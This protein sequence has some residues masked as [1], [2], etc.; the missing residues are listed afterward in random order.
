MV[1]FTVL[2]LW[3]L[4]SRLGFTAVGIRCLLLGFSI[5]PCLYSSASDSLG[6]PFGRFL[7]CPYLEGGLVI[8]LP[9][10]AGFYAPAWV[11]GERRGPIC[12]I[13]I[14]AKEKETPC[15][16]LMNLTT[17]SEVGKPRLRKNV[18]LD[19][20]FFQRK[21]YWYTTDLRLIMCSFL[22]TSPSLGNDWLGMI[23]YYQLPFWHW[24]ELHAMTVI[25][26]TRELLAM[27]KLVAMI[28][29]L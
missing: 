14:L 10:Q 5:T 24:L 22:I 4:V 13:P 2:R 20:A 17:R 1:L 21:L 27:T 12:T 6:L 19:W 23:D 8:Y 3:F 26:L 28:I 25:A 7:S 9:C 16:G 29:L 11:M 15:L 18:I